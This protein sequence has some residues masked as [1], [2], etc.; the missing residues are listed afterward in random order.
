M[1]KT[2]VLFILIIVSSF[3]NEAYKTY[4]EGEKLFVW[5]KSGLNLRKEPSVNAESIGTIK[6]GTQITVLNQDD[7]ISYDYAFIKASNIRPDENNSKNPIFLNGYWI[8]IK[9]GNLTGYVFS[10]LLLKYKP[11][12]AINTYND[13]YF[14]NYFQEIFKMNFIEDEIFEVDTYTKELYGYT[15]GYRQLFQSVT[16]ENQMELDTEGINIIEVAN[17]SFQEALVL[18][19]IAL[20]PSDG[21]FVNI[22]EFNKSITYQIPLGHPKSGATILRKG[23]KIYFDWMIVPWD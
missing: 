8:K 20:P 23:N 3:G 17:I 18:F 2:I 16:L 9:A 6:Y 11:Y 22:Y 12:K 7:K 5:A 4:K 15:K 1:K 19:M 14:S 21:I 10:G 13:I